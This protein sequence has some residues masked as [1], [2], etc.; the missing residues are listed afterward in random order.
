MGRRGNQEGR[1][2]GEGRGEERVVEVG[3]ENEFGGRWETRERVRHQRLSRDGA[4]LSSRD[5]EGK[6]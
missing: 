2:R 3:D 5:G 1:E 6:E 4:I